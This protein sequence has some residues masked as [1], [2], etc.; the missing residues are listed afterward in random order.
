MRHIQNDSR[1]SAVV[2]IKTAAYD[3]VSDFSQLFEFS[4]HSLLSYSAI[5][6]PLNGEYAFFYSADN[7]QHSFTASYDAILMTITA[8]I[9]ESS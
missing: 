6:S 4:M 1:I 5:G 9:Q 8:Y 2:G 3:A 7:V